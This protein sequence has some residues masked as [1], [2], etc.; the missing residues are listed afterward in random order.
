[1]AVRVARSAH[2]PE[3]DEFRR[4]VRVDDADDQRWHHDERERSFLIRHDA[5]RPERRRSAV[6]SQIV[7]PNRRWR[8]KQERRDR[9]KHSEG[10]RE[11]LR[12]LHLGD[13]GREQDLRHPEERDVEHG[14]H[15][16][17]P[18]CA[19]ER[20]GVGFHWPVGR[21]VPVVAVEGRIFDAGED[22]E[23]ED[24]EGHACRWGGVNE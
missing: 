8:D 14:V 2:D 19:G 9:S 21:V 24:R 13:E 11:I 15:A 20:E 12:P 6:L 4:H 17:D 7:E 22:E 5:Q 18:G 10:F 16:C 23:E 3:V 1:M